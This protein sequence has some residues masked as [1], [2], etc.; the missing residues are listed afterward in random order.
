MTSSKKSKGICR[1]FGG[2]LKLACHVGQL[3]RKARMGRGAASRWAAEAGR[4]VIQSLR[5]EVLT[6]RR[7]YRITMR[8][9]IASWQIDDNKIAIVR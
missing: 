4:R 2:D 3:R 6:L 8:C 5:G 1:Y 9:R 7:K